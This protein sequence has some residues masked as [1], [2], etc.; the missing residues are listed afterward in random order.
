[1]FSTSVVKNQIL[2]IFGLMVSICFICIASLLPTTLDHTSSWPFR[3]QSVYGYGLFSRFP[4]ARTPAHPPVFYRTLSF[5]L[6]WYQYPPITSFS[7]LLSSLEIAPMFFSWTITCKPYFPLCPL[8]LSWMNMSLLNSH[9]TCPKDHSPTFDTVPSSIVFGP[10]VIPAFSFCIL[11][12][13]WYCAFVH[14]VLT[15]RASS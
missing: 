10:S 15:Q 14:L 8:S 3:F 4:L 2:A 7:P 9:N 6:I 13:L 12:L 1:M 5:V 11:L